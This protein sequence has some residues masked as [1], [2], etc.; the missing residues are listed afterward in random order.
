[1]KRISFFAIS[2]ISVMFFSS[3]GYNTMQAKE[4]AVLAAWGNVEAGRADLIFSKPRAS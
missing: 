4:E 3:C 1:M 2:L